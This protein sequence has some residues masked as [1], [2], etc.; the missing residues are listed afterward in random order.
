MTLQ[1]HFDNLKHLYGTRNATYM[2]DGNTRVLLLGD[3]VRH[4]GKL[5]RKDEKNK[6]QL[7]LA[8]ASVF[9]RTCAF[10]DIFADLSIVQSLS[11]KYPL[12]ACA[13]CNTKPCT[14]STAR[15]TQITP[16]QHNVIQ[17]HWGIEDW[18][19]HMNNLYGENNKKQGVMFAFHRLAE[20]VL[21]AQGTQLIDKYNPE[22]SQILLR[23]RIS[24]EFADIFAWIFSLSNLLETNL[25]IAL[26]YRYGSNCKRCDGRPCRCGPFWI[27]KTHTHPQSQVGS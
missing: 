23:F 13:Y 2:P 9:A 26:V 21:E 17:L 4:L 22:M 25:E 11:E 12:E 3:G 8:L 14:C 18:S 20:E 5:L 1:E 24:C 27:Y 19:A 6:E 16:R 15:I 10:A 7:G